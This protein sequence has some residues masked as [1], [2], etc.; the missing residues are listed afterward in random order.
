MLVTTHEISKKF[1]NL[2]ALHNL[3]LQIP[4]GISGFMGKNGSGKTTTI[5]VLVGLIKPQSGEAQIFGLDCWDQS[6]AIRKRMGVMHEINSYP[7]GF[8]GE[9][10]LKHVARFYSVSNP[11]QRVNEVLREVGLPISEDRQIKGYSA[12]M[13]RRL[14]LAQALIGD[15]EFIVLD[16]P[17]ANVDPSGRIALLDKITDL[18]KSRGTSFLISTHILSD[19]E[20]ICDWISIIDKGTIVEQGN[21]KDLSKKYSANIFKISVSNPYLFVQELMRLNTVKKAWIEKDDIFTNVENIDEFYKD[22][23]SIATQNKVQLKGLQRV[24]G[25]IEEIYESTTN[26]KNQVRHSEPT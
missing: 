15:P 24:V 4:K 9:Q 1:G 22:V 6:F 16:E 18:N 17:T 7:S 2:T 19:L 3:N 5:G 26:E 13:L 21:V 14:G 8:T 12:G 23:L 11:N 10:F 25:T 20:K